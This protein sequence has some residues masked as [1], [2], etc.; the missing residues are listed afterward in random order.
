MIALY[1]DPPQHAAVFCGDEETAIQA[2]GPRDRLDPVVPRSPR[3]AEK[4]GLEYYRHGTLSLSAALEV[5]T[6]KVHGKTARRHTRVD[7]IGFL[8]DRVERSPAGQE[9]H[10][11]LDH[12]SAHKTPAVKEF[13]D[14]NP[15]VRFHFTSKS[16]LPRSSATSSP[17]ASSLP[18]PIFPA[19]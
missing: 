5:K 17:A 2:L 15:Q 6:G 10:I 11:E 9:I 8:A 19:S 3:R 1:M 18:S 4:H 16:G 12:L 13:L 7:F 14:P